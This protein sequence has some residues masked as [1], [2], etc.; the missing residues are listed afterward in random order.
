[1]NMSHNSSE[2]ENMR[3]RGLSL[4]C[5]A[6]LIVLASVAVAEVPTSMNVQGC[7]TDLSGT[8]VPAGEKDFTFKIFDTEALATGT[9]LWPGGAGEYQ[10][11]TT[12]TQGRWNARV[13]SVIPLTDVVYSDTV[14]WLEVTV[15]YGGNPAETLS[16]IRLLTG[17]FA[18]RVATVD[19]ASGGTITS[20]LTVGSD[21]TNTSNHAF[22]AGRYCEVG[23]NYA[24]VS[25]G[26]SN[27]ALNDHSTVGGGYQD[28]ALAIYATVSGGIQN[29]ARGSR[30]TVSGGQDNKA[31]AFYSA[32]GG[33]SGNTVEG[34]HS[35]IPGGKNNTIT[36]DGDYSCL[37]GLN[38]TLTQDS[39][40]MVD[41]THIRFGDEGNGYEFPTTDGATGQ[42]LASDGAGLLGWSDP[43]GSG[44]RWYSSDS[45]LYTDHYL[46][47]AR[48]NAF[49]ALHGAGAH[50]MTNWGG[51]TC[52]TGTSGQDEW[53]PT[54]GGGLGNVAY[55]WSATVAGGTQ[56]RA[57]ESY[58]FIGA[59]YQNS[60]NG[61]FS[62]IVGGDS[63]HV[64]G[65][66]SAILGGI[67]D[68]ITSR[69]SFLFGIRSKLTK[70]STFM[71][72][73]PNI[74]FGDEI[75][76]YEFPVS[77]GTSGQILTTDGSGQLA[78]A[79][80]PVP[81]NGW[82]DLGS[83]V[84]LAAISD[85]VGIGTSAPNAKLHVTDPGSDDC[86]VIIESQGTGGSVISRIQ[87]ATQ[88]GGNGEITKYNTGRLAVGTG[89]ASDLQLRTNGGGSVTVSIGSTDVINVESDLQ[90]GIGTDS[91]ANQ[92]DVAGNMAIGSGY[93]SWF[94]GPTDGLLVEGKVGIGTSTPQNKLDLEGGLAVGASYSG[95][96]SAPANG[97]IVQGNVGL[98]TS[99]VVNRLD[100]E[101]GA[102]IGAT[103]AGTS[104]APTNGLI[105]EGNV[106]IG[107]HSP[108][109]KL[110]LAENAS[111]LTFPL[112]LDNYHST[113]FTDATGI[114]FAVGGDGGGN[115]A[116]ERGKGAL[117]YDYSGIW[118]RGKFH[119][120][121]NSAT[122][123]S[124]PTLADAVMTIQNNGNIGIGTTTPSEP[125][126]VAGN[127]KVLGNIC[128]GS[129][130][131][132]SDARLKH[133]IS[134][135][136]GAT[137]TV[138]SLRG[139]RFDWRPEA[140][141]ERGLLDE[142]QIGLIAQEVEL[143]VPE[144]VHEMSD[145]YEAV[146]YSRLVPVLIEAI[147]EQQAQ[148]DELK[149]TVG[150]LAEGQH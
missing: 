49:N 35:T 109:R 122:D 98:G 53:F 58:S 107:L 5:I 37:I 88:E 99:N 133:N 81:N 8:P 119:F 16:R 14:C 114:L 29:T 4:L 110:Y 93:S 10:S 139:V 24:T 20:K 106:G 105:V 82:T 137:E 15:E 108:N 26:Q 80:L 27:A 73:M 30:A 147:K 92:L 11:I 142:P 85:S 78:W 131:C 143:V 125:L 77:D 124:N 76:G 43:A 12:D 63:N 36:A 2:E 39:T 91:P 44:A 21:N 140:I 19:G 115:L 113:F 128:A 72:D 67:G 145:G 55:G 61:W 60:V 38:S 89:Q 6:V 7:L 129:I 141:A 104:A 148:I 74:R 94:T 149:A 118:N 75:N 13:G 68:T 65:A 83:R 90:V 136:H 47:L 64:T 66:H 70:D 150:R 9:E 28:S 23:G 101:G 112:K 121:Q 48:G 1:M 102:A 135:I 87:L 59:G 120:L 97:L 138:Q 31:E 57:T 116:E 52:T 95:D 130:G 84:G 126:D 127:L 40:F 100:V 117:V 50:T 32:I 103:Y 22:V 132:P 56:N 41:L 79:E 134:P 42:F 45:V 46:G 3:T 111:G 86:D 71:V 33:G 25:G 69:C 146:D 34:L 18:Y 96:H 144:A 17:P 54:V 51:M 123:D 62:S